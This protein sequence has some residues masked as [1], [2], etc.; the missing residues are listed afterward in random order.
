MSR[1]AALAASLAALAPSDTT[2]IA[3]PPLPPTVSTMSTVS[4][5]EAP[6]RDDEAAVMQAAREA[7]AAGA[8]PMLPEAEHRAAV[9]GLMRAALMR[10]PSW[11]DRPDCRPAQGAWCGG[12]GRHPPEYGGRWWQEREAPTGWRCW[13]CYP[14]AHLKPDNVREVAT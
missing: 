11:S 13:T 2:D 14:P 12:C 3:I 6:Q 8:D 5:G 1:W 7:D 10:P 4:P 9:A